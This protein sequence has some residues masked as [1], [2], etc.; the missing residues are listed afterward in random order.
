[1]VRE[2][3]APIAALVIILFTLAASL[4]AQLGDSGPHY[5]SDHNLAQTDD[6][7]SYDDSEQKRTLEQTDKGSVKKASKKND[8]VCV[9]NC[10]DAWRP[11]QL[12]PWPI[13][14]PRQ[15]I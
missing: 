9:R 6:N 8:N 3:S 12:T 11:Y 10:S 13:N 5:A 14:E 15:S 2:M 7:S 4:N 1:M